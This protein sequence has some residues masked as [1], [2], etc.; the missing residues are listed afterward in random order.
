MPKRLLPALALAPILALVFVLAPAQHAHAQ[1]YVGPVVAYRDDFDF[2]IGGFVSVPIPSIAEGL[3]LLGDLGIS[4][5]D[6][7]PGADRSYFEVN[8]GVPYRFE[9]D[10]DDVSPFAMGGLNI[11]RVRPSVGL[12]IPLRGGEG[13][14][15]FGA[16]GFPVG[17][18]VRC[19]APRRRAR[20]VRVSQS[21]RSLDRLLRP[22]ASS[23][24][25]A[26]RSRCASVA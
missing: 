17:E 26:S 6:D 23:R 11:A 1:T 12:K 25:S 21:R 14:V 16:L 20:A 13:F 5:P 18:S 19:H 7:A 2:G 4:F 9:V 8:G 24:A 10:S 15:L 3:H 22:A